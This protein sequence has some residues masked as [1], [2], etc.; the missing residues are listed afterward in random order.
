MRMLAAMATVTSKLPG[1]SGIQLLDPSYHTLRA[2]VRF[3]TILAY[4]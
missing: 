1:I 2:A 4:G 3:S